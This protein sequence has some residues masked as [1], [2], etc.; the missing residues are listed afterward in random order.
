MSGLAWFQAAVTLAVLVMTWHEYALSAVTFVWRPTLLDTPLPFLI[1]CTE[2]VVAHTI[3]APSLLW[4]GPQ[5]LFLGAILLAYLNLLWQAARHPRNRS[6]LR[7]PGQPPWRDPTWLTALGVGAGVLL[8]GALFGLA[9]VGVLAPSGPLGTAVVVVL[10]V[11]MGLRS[12]AYWQ[13]LVGEAE[14]SGGRG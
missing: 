7:G 3:G 5:A 4:L 2:V 6:L 14:Q 10:I 12:L 13:Y 9:Q 1:G 11:G 8:C